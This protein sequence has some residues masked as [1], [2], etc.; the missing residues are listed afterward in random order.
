MCSL[1]KTTKHFKI[2]GPKVNNRKKIRSPNRVDMSRSAVEGSWRID[3]F[4][5]LD[6]SSHVS[7]FLKAMGG[8]S[9]KHRIT[10]LT[11]FTTTDKFSPLVVNYDV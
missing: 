10:N 4:S 6:L 5:G 2:Q 7:L 8:H 11:F 9:E 1:T 3:F